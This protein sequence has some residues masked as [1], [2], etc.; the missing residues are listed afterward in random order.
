MKTKQ[1][2]LSEWL[3]KGPHLSLFNNHPDAIYVLDLEGNYIDA[4]LA[5]KDLTGYTV[6]E[7]IALHPSEIIVE[8]QLTNRM[9]ILQKV[10][11]NVKEEYEVYFHHKRGYMLIALVIYVPIMEGNETIGFYGIAKDISEKKEIE[12]RM[13]D[14]E[15]RF[16]LLSENSLDMIALHTTDEEKFI[17]VS[18]ASKHLLGYEPEELIGHSRYE[19]FHPED[20]ASIFQ[21]HKHDMGR[22]QEYKLTHRAKRKE[23]QYIWLET[24]GNFIVDEETGEIKECITVSRDITDRK[25]IEEKYKINEQWYKSLFDYN[26][27]AVFSFDING[28]FISHNDNFNKLTGYSQE[29]INSMSFVPFVA[30]KDLGRTAAHFEKAKKGVPQHYETTLVEKNGEHRP[31]QVSNLPIIVDGNIVGVYGIA[32]DISER[33][34]AREQLKES[35]QRYRSLFEYNPSAV[36][37]F[38]NEGN[39]TSA[40]R[41]LELLSG[42]NQEELLEMNYSALIHP[43]DLEYTHWHFEQ[44]MEGIAQNYDISIIRNDGRLIEANIINIPIIVN[45]KVTGV[46]GIG[47]DITDRK[48]YMNQVESLSNQNRL[49]LNSVTEGIAGLDQSGNILFINEAGGKIL[50]LNP[51][52]A[53][54]RM[55]ESLMADRTVEQTCP[56]N[57]T[58]K[59]GISRVVEKDTLYLKNGRE[60]PIQYS[61]SPMY[62][63]GI[64]TGTVITFSDI[65]DKLRIEQLKKE[66]EQ[67]ELEF[68]LA[69]HVQKSLLTDVSKLVL[70][71]QTDL[72][73]VSIPIRKLN[74]DF[75]NVVS[76]GE[77]IR[78]AIADISGKGMAAAILMSM[79]KYAMD[80]SEE[81][82]LP[83][84]ILD[85][86]NQYCAKYLDPSMF[87][88]MFMGTY[89]VMTSRFQYAS[90]GHE[91]GIIYKHEENEMFD[92]NARGAVLGLS[93]DTVYLTEEYQLHGKDMVL[94]YTDGI[95]EERL[96]SGVDSNDNLKELLSQVDKSK[97]AQ[98]IIQ[99]LYNE[100]RRKQKDQIYDDQTLFLFKKV[101]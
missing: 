14:S 30:P 19:H 70:P 33:V 32:F 47:T 12:K 44:A 79:I 94:L 52:E 100:I 27:A 72:G 26:P 15:K 37:S 7:F 87:V 85:E 20:I 49:I 46:Y 83:H 35:E 68:R 2:N 21:Q 66:H 62:E 73:V 67:I 55:A 91:P 29:E 40:N 58:L 25:L 90:A 8:E 41:A 54:G 43:D 23:G 81:H 11:S 51:Q 48:R 38:N 92:I 101:N 31:V 1:E 80:K 75:Y 77:Q 76:N 97:S 18:P 63:Q 64:I 34:W 22:N 89:D 24:T 16:R 56:A 13:Y 74:G 84:E 42:Y 45:Q 4:N 82:T 5:I 60:M 96:N 65:T 98:E 36:Y 69:S 86:L 88:T 39:F 6:P 3:G 99:S 17:Y 93:K 59:D 53:A 50:G 71:H 57:Q 28:D 9:E 95:T 78:F 61:I 10:C